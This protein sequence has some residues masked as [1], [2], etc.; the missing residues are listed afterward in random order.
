MLHLSTLPKTCLPNA[1]VSHNQLPFF[2]C[3]PSRPQLEIKE[4]RHSVSTPLSRLQYAN[5]YGRRPLKPGVGRPG[6]SR[7]RTG[8]L[9]T[10]ARGSF[11]ET[12]SLQFWIGSQTEGRCCWWPWRR[13]G[14][15]LHDVIAIVRCTALPYRELRVCIWT[16]TSSRQETRLTKCLLDIS[17][18]RACRL[19]I[20]LLDNFLAAYIMYF[21]H[22]W[23]LLTTESL[24][25]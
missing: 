12:D 18:Q 8:R 9:P 23:S 17:K 4:M 11:V 20:V 3:I 2:H 19:S 6:I 13:E 5:L 7:R 21:F 14:N 25:G 16:S 10:A 15:W 22:I 1:F 24:I